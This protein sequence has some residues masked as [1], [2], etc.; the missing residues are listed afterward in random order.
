MP[1][2]GAQLKGDL[3]CTDCGLFSSHPWG[4]FNHPTLTLLGLCLARHWRG[5]SA[6]SST[7]RNIPT[8]QF[9]Q[10]FI[11]LL[12]FAVHKDCRADFL[13]IQS[14]LWVNI[15]GQN[16]ENERSKPF[17]YI[18]PFSSFFFGYQRCCWVSADPSWTWLL[19]RTQYLQSVCFVCENNFSLVLMMRLIF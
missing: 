12:C 7:I 17:W 14:Q 5:C 4:T 13:F 10:S 6:W 3:S 16:L 9:A 11:T 8:I 1:N 15:T 2:T 19:L 18:V